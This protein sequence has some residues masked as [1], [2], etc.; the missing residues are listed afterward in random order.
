MSSSLYVAEQCCTIGFSLCYIS[1]VEGSHDPPTFLSNFGTYTCSVDMVC[2]TE[3]NAH[4][5]SS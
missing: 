2:E 4:L 1:S 3:G 5:Y